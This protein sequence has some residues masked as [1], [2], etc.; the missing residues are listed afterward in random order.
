MKK[1]ILSSLILLVVFVSCK[2]QDV[3]NDSAQKPVTIGTASK[4]KTIENWIPSDSV[5]KTSIADD[6]ISS[7]IVSNGLVLVYAKSNNANN[8]LPAQI[9]KNYFYYQV[10]NGSL[11]ITADDIAPDKTLQFCYIIFSKDQLSMLEQKGISSTQL[12]KM[13]YQQITE[14]KN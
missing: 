13:N 12:M 8:L 11:Q 6:K 1:I 14:L 2:K 10:E 7:D 9:G 5:Y 3:K 4:W